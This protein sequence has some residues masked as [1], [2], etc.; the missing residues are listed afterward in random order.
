MSDCKR[1][2]VKNLLLKRFLTTYCGEISWTFS[3]SIC[4]Y[5]LR[6]P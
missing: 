4:L 2:A 1:K 5:A 3:V 6:C